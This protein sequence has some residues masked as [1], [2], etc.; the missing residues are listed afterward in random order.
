MDGTGRL[1]TKRLSECDLRHARA[2][3]DVRRGDRLRPPAPALFRGLLIQKAVPSSTGPASSTSRRRITGRKFTAGSRNGAPANCCAAFSGPAG[4]R[5]NYGENRHARSLVLYD[6]DEK[7]GIVTLN[8]PEKLDAISAELQEQLTDAFAR[9][10]AD[11]QTSVVLLRVE[12]RSFCAGYDISAKD[13][14]KHDWRG[15]PPGRM[16]ICACNS[17]SGL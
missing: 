1:G 10:D 12:G 11:L 14:A 16:S 7:V 15:D 13:P 5:L 8:R 17:I 2:L 4:S 3:R 9:A 6:V